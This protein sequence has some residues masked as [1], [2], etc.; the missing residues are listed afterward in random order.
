MSNMNTETFGS[1]TP[2]NEVDRKLLHRAYVEFRECIQHSINEGD[3]ANV[4]TE[5]SGEVL[6]DELDRIATDTA[7]RV[8]AAADPGRNGY[9][10]DDV[11]LDL[12]E[13]YYEAKEKMYKRIE[14][15]R[16]SR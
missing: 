10:L 15:V 4:L 6:E 14:T 1:Q 9:S 2:R 5:F 11:T 16:S 8:Q 13:V 12:D 3:V 7:E